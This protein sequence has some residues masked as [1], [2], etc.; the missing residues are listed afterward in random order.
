MAAW[1]CPFCQRPQVL[2]NHNYKTA[3]S[4][5]YVTRNKLGDFGAYVTAIA[6]LNE[7]CLEVTFSVALCNRIDEDRIKGESIKMWDLLPESAAK[8][9]PAFIPIAVRNDYIEACRIRELSAKASATLARRCLQGMIR[10]FTGIAKNRLIDEINALR[11]AVDDGSAPPGISGGDIDAIDGV[12]KI[13]NIG[14]HME[15]DVDL[16]VDVEAGEA[17]ILIDLI[18]MLFE[19]WYVARHERQE[20]LAR[21]AALSAEKSLA[22]ENAKAEK[23][24]AESV[25]PAP[26]AK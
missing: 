21:V 25:T 5:L 14:A 6:C 24:K 19:E 11:K 16:I 20:R 8:P 22:L 13:G 1:T 23:L 7:D 12:R 17:Q 10:D 3:W 18:E 4:P 9:Q 15:K 2:T 26:N